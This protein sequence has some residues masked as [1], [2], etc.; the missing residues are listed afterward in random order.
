MRL[1]AELENVRAELAEVRAGSAAGPG[2]G[3][4]AMGGYGADVTGGISAEEAASAASERAP[5]RF[6]SWGEA[7]CDAYALAGS[8]GP[9]C[10]GGWAGICIEGWSDA[11]GGGVA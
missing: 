9:E 3:P 1:R 8:L 2:P 4:D 6:R 7:T 11:F 5:A 10:S